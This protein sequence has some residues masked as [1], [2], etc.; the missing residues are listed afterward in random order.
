MFHEVHSSRVLHC[1]S[2]NIP[3]IFNCV[4]EPRYSVGRWHVYLT[5]LLPLYDSEAVEGGNYCASFQDR[6][7]SGACGLLT[8]L[9][10]VCLEQST[11]VRYSPKVY[12]P[13]TS[14]ATR[15]VE[16]H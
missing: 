7:T 15:P 6:H 12:I 13:S 9:Y 3:N 5:S 2:K 8:D 14:R 16:L 10:H 4:W 1:V 11:R